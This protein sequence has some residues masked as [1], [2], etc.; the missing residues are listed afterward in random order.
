MC[1]FSIRGEVID[2][3]DNKSLNDAIVTVEETNQQVLTN[4]QEFLLTGMCAQN[5]TLIIRHLQCKELRKQISPPFSGNK[6]F[7]LEHHINELEEIIVM[8]LSRKNTTKTGI[9]GS[10]SAV[11]VRRYRAQSLGDA[12]AQLSGWSALK[13]GNA[14]VKPMAHGVTEPDWPL[15][16][17]E[18][19]FKTM[20]GEPITRQVLMSTG[21]TPF[22]GSKEQ[23]ALKYGG[24]ALSGVLEIIP[25]KFKQE[26]ARATA[27]MV[28]NHKEK[29]LCVNRLF[30][31]SPNR[32]VLWYQHVIKKCRRFRKCRLCFDQYGQSRGSFKCVHG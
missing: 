20:N 28:T 3:H 32:K 16:M 29:D 31:N 11:E 10:L 14:I 30:Q 6:R 2:L 24:D 19:A 21:A 5:Y 13:T 7:Y 25:E 9:E 8:E 12:L 23:N 26:D 17:P 1:S 18:Y 22:N 27:T 4:L 15:S